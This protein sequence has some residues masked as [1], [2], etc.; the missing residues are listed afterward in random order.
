MERWSPASSP[1]SSMMEARG[2]VSFARELAPFAQ[3]GARDVQESG[4]FAQE[5]G[6]FRNSSPSL[7]QVRAA[8]HQD[9]GGESPSRGDEPQSRPSERPYRAPMLN[10]QTSRAKYPISA[11]YHSSSVSHVCAAMSRELHDEPRLPWAIGRTAAGVPRSPLTSGR[12][13]PCGLGDCGHRV[14]YRPPLCGRQPRPDGP[15]PRP[16]PSLLRVCN[17]YGISAPCL[18]AMCR[19]VAVPG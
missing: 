12:D 5:P 3:E 16:R 18:V 10:E 7:P 14:Q 13:F 9:P 1:H 8:S 2:L 19:F 11:P 15:V 4:P 17:H 6:P